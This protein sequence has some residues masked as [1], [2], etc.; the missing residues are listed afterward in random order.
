V[1]ANSF[2]DATTNSMTAWTMMN[3][4]GQDDDG[5]T[6]MLRMTA[7]TMPVQM[8]MVR[9]MMDVDGKDDD[10]TTIMARMMTRR[11]GGWKRRQDEVVKTNSFFDATTTQ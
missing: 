11:E 3:D 8:M 1:E 9:T 10:G 2:F 6:I 5:A 4:D 7:R